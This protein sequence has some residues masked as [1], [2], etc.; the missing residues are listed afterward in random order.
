MRHACFA[1]ASLGFSTIGPPNFDVAHLNAFASR[2]RQSS[3]AI[4]KL[5]MCLNLHTIACGAAD[6]RQPKTSDQSEAKVTHASAVN[7][8]VATVQDKILRIPVAKESLQLAPRH[9]IGW[10]T[11]RAYGLWPE[12]Q[13]TS[14]QVRRS[15]KR[16]VYWH[17]AYNCNSCAVV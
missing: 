1:S 2:L 15:A 10:F 16:Q 5:R 7:E 3:C 4:F 14:S 12:V 6:L 17:H 11:V 13:G 9:H 8:V